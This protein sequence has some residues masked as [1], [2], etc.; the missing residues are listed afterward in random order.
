[1]I[2]RLSARFAVFIFA[3][4]PIGY[5]TFECYRLQ[6]GDAF[7]RGR[8]AC[9]NTRS[10]S[11]LRGLTIN[12][13]DVAGDDSGMGT[14]RMPICSLRRALA[15]ANDLRQMGLPM[16]VSI[17]VRQVGK[18]VTLVWFI[19]FTSERAGCAAGKRKDLYPQHGEMSW[20]KV[21]QI[22]TWC[23]NPASGQKLCRNDE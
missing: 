5:L 13:W 12:M 4:I 16:A 15:S 3:G 8:M 17:W 11:A 1:V 23:R 21:L 10:A 14:S 19:S 18:R 6:A 7:L 20:I 9:E 22:S 2:H